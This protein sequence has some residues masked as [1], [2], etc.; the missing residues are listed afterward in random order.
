VKTKIHRLLWGLLSLLVFY[1]CEEPRCLRFRS[2]TAWRSQQR[3]VLERS[4]A[5]H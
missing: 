4:S 1:P 5:S 2:S 3:R